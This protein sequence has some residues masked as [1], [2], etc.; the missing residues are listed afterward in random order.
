MYKLEEIPCPHCG[1]VMSDQWEV[2]EV[3]YWG[4]G[5]EIVVECSQCDESFIY[6]EFVKREY[7]I[8]RS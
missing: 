6:R 2:F 1:H 5:G 8:Y 3:T 7:A 4:E